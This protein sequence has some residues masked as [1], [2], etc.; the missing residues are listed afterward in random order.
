MDGHRSRQMP[1]KNQSAPSGGKGADVRE[2]ECQGCGTQG[3]WL[4]TGLGSS[5]DFQDHRAYQMGDD[6]RY[7]HW[8]AYA[9]TGL[10]TMKLYRAEVAPLVETVAL[11]DTPGRE[12]PAMM[13]TLD[14]S[15]CSSP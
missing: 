14:C 8:A 11:T 6:P 15:T 1:P 3:N 4:G 9:R 10:L 12:K 13:G 2:W 7:I 5:V